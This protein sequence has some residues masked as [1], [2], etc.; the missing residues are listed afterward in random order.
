MLVFVWVYN[1]VDLI[2]IMTMGGPAYSSNV[3]GSYMYYTA[4]TSYEL[5][6]ASVFAVVSMA[7]LAIVIIAYLYL[8]RRGANE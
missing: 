1:Y 4:F 6:Y 5:G 2:I 3:L 7:I 8:I